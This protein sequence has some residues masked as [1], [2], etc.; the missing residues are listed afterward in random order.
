M[1]GERSLKELYAEYLDGKTTFEEVDRA[2]EAFLARYRQ[3]RESEAGRQSIGDP[4]AKRP[5]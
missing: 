1:T 2:S 3:A 5:S 4:P